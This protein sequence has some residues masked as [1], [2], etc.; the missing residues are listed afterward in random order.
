MRKK[1]YVNRAM[2]ASKDLALARVLLLDTN[3]NRQYPARPK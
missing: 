3:T 1:Q 2:N